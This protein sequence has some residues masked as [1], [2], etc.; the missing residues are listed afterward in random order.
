MK[1][2]TLCLKITTFLLLIWTYQC[3]YNCYSYKTL[4]DKNTMQIKNELKYRRVLTEGDIEGKKKTYVEGCLEECPLDKKKK[5]KKW[6]NPFKS[7]NP[8]YIWQRDTTPYLW[9]HFQNETSEMDPKW[10][11]EKWSNEWKRISANKV[12]DL[13]SIFHRSDISKEEKERLIYS[14]EKELFT[15]FV[16]FLDKCKNE[17]RDNKTESESKKEMIDNR[18]EFEPKKETRDNK[19]ESESEKEMRDNKTESE[20][21]KEMTDNKTE[22]ESEKETRDNKIEYESEKE[23]RDNK[24]ESESEKEMRHNKEECES[25]KEMT[26]NNTKS[27][28]E[29]EMR[30][31]KTESESTKVQGT[32]KIKNY[33]KKISKL[34]IVLIFLRRIKINGLTE[35]IGLVMH[36]I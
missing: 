27:E 1:M 5:K 20:S 17:M 31:N 32:N 25:E 34:I 18:T 16:E 22:S 14:V 13:S 10:R 2:L 24:T 8:Y 29:K 21:E 19:A 9:E 30:D 12:N 33:K 4:I 15:L 23:M 28:S 3:F 7:K 11:D 36:K 35:N 26:D 6:K